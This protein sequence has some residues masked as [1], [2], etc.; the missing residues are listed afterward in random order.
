MPLA[1][2]LSAC[3]RHD[4]PARIQRGNDAAPCKDP[5]IWAFFARIKRPVSGRFQRTSRSP[6]AGS[7]LS[8]PGPINRRGTVT[9]RAPS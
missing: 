4:R 9:K 5:S 3:H 8:H 7:E 1:T 2:I 6:A